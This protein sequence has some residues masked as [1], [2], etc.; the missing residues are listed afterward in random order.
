M[1]PGRG[2]DRTT[3]TFAVLALG[4]IS[5]SL[6]QSLVAPALPAIQH[7]LH[8]SENAVSWVLTSYL[9]S[10]SVATPVLGQLS[11]RYGRKPVLALSLAGTSFGYALF[12]IGIVVRNIPLLFLARALDGITGGNLS[13]AQASIADVTKPEDRTKNFG[14][15]GAAFGVGFVVGPALGSVAALGGAR[16]PFI[17]AGVIA[18]ANALVPPMSPSGMPRALRHIASVTKRKRFPSQ[19]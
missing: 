13:V 18:G 4:A 9:L 17:L 19:V 12:A 3:L 5:Y 1:D 6:L 10:A 2:R 14:L 11:D 16:L 7:E 15:I 8:C